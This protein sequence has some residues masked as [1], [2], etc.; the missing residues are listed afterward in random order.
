MTLIEGLISDCLDDAASMTVDRERWLLCEA[1][2]WGLAWMARTR[3]A[4]GSAGGLLE[5]LVKSARSAQAPLAAGDTLRQP[6]L[7]ATL[8][9]I[10]TGGP[11]AF[12]EGPLAERM[13]T[14]VARAGGIWTSRDLREYEA[15]WRAPLVFGYRGH[16]VA[17]MPPP[18]AG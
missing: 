5:R 7:A 9:S 13:A 12:Y 1:A 8:A 15:K 10:A 11:R 3:R 17:T 2:T 18:S 4:G 14:E 6:E 16:E